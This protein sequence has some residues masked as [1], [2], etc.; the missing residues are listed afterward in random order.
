MNR[1]MATMLGSV[2][3]LGAHH[4]ASASGHI[5]EPI[6]LATFVFIIGRLLF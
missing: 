5:G 3:G 2:A 6:L 4:L 1:T